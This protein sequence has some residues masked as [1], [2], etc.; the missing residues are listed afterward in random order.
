MK[1]NKFFLLS[2]VVNTILVYFFKHENFWFLVWFNVLLIVPNEIFSR[3]N[4]GIGNLVIGYG[5]GTMIGFAFLRTLQDCII[6]SLSLGFF[7]SLTILVI[8]NQIETS[9]H[10]S[11]S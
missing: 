11:E 7:F 4:L 10:Q 6:L 3:C 1:T 9:S 2:I 5:L 8:K